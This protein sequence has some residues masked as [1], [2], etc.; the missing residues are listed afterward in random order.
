M[1]Q[2]RTSS[3]NESVRV[4]Q[5]KYRVIT[6]RDGQV[7]NSYDLIQG[8]GRR[9][10]PINTKNVF[11]LPCSLVP[12]VAEGLWADVDSWM[13]RSDEPQ[14]MD[15]V[16]LGIHLVQSCLLGK[17]IKTMLSSEPK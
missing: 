5:P 14:R 13:G 7:L 3:S 11:P 6:S 1:T 17:W 2:C 8:T 4:Q 10:N 12:A 15:G 16:F 9:Q